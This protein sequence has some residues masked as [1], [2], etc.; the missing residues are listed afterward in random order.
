MSFMNKQIARAPALYRNAALLGSCSEDGAVAWLRDRPVTISSVMG[1]IDT[2][3]DAHILE[4]I[5]LRRR[6]P[7]IDIALAEH[8]RSATILSRVYR[9]SSDSV[10]VTACSNASL[11]VGDTFASF[12]R[13]DQN[14][15]WDIIFDGPIAQLRSI[16]E[17]PWISS[18]FYGSLIEAWQP[19][20]Q[21]EENKRYLPEDR[22]IA[23][24][25]FLSAN[26]R[27]SQSREESAE[28]HYIDGFADYHYE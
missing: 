21:R 25:N 14:L 13:H 22:Y 27:I 6:S 12:L 9:R 24:L 1:T 10:R 28:R 4:Y 2:P 20:D 5:L 15:L 26:P 7:A 18:G 11:F 8:G 3:N 19:E 16:C 17:N 23:V